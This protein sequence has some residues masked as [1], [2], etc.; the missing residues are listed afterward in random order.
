MVLRKK[1][2]KGEEMKIVRYR[3]LLIDFRDPLPPL[4]SS[5]AT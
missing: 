4:Y 3:I 5:P 2:L 1:A